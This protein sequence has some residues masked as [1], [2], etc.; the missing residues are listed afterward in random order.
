MLRNR[1]EKLGRGFGT[2]NFA[3]MCVRD[4]DF[5]VEIAK[6]I[7]N[8]DLAGM[9]DDT[10][11]FVLSV[12]KGPQ[13]EE[14]LRKVERQHLE[15]AAMELITLVDTLP[16]N[17]RAV[18]VSR[19]SGLSFRKIREYRKDRAMFSLVDDWNDSVR[20]IWDSSEELVRRII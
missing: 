15:D 14:A 16:R 8:S 3:S 10:R 6:D 17:L 2:T 9:R 1:R 19:A 7:F 5:F 11:D 12:I 20:Y 18:T 4:H 13:L